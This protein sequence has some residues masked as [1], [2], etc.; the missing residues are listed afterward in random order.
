MRNRKIILISLVALT[1]LL[2]IFSIY[3]A[4]T[5][6]STTDNTE[7]VSV[8]QSCACC[9][10]GSSNT[11]TNVNGTHVNYGDPLA[12]SQPECPQSFP[13]FVGC[14]DT[15]PVCGNGQVESGEAC[16]GGGSIACT[17]STG[18]VGTKTCSGCQYGSCISTQYCGD[19]ICSGPETLA[20][21]PSDCTNCGDGICS[22]SE[23]GTTCAADCD[24]ECN[25]N[26][27]N[28]G[29]GQIDCSDP[30]CLDSSGTCDPTKDLEGIDFACN[31]GIDNDGDGKIDCGGPNGEAADPGCFPDGLGGGTCSTLD[32]SEVDGV[33]LPATG[34]IDNNKII[35][36]GIGLLLLSLG[37]LLFG[38]K[39]LYLPN[40][41]FTLEA[42]SKPS[43]NP[44]YIQVHR[45]HKST[46]QERNEFQEK[47]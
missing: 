15:G 16:E 2:G 40:I 27:D 25:D 32:R 24:T 31:D 20:T 5:L 8:A 4:Y 3:F 44:T 1:S 7:D 22:D 41:E 35:Y 14:F 46:Y 6:S 26:L 36:F 34:F 45:K 18:Y 12:G 21:C 10:T 30:Q 9:V 42:E 13:I 19:N 43:L 28:D 33:P 29:D 39:F 17:N 38:R 11:C 23:T 37:V 47:F